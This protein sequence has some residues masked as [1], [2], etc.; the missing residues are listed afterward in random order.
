M[1]GPQPG[2]DLL[3]EGAPGLDDQHDLVLGDE[4]PVPPEERPAGRGDVDARGEPF[5]R[6]ASG[7]PLSGGFVR[8]RR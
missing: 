2:L 3:V 8:D 6:E 4:L 1:Q 5:F 7:E